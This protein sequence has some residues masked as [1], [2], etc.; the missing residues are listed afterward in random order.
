MIRSDTPQFEG[1]RSV[2]S[3]LVRE[4]DSDFEVDIPVE[5]D[6]GLT[7]ERAYGVCPNW[8]DKFSP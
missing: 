6:G 7:M 1:V 8:K 5:V 3:I 2:H 4:E